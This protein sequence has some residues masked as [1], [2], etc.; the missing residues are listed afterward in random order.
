MDYDVIHRF[1]EAAVKKKLLTL[2]AV[3]LI[4]LAAYA[5]IRIPQLKTEDDIREAVL[6][7]EF[8]KTGAASKDARVYY[9]SV[10]SGWSKRSLSDG[11]PVLDTVLNAFGLAREETDRWDGPSASSGL[12]GRFS[13][14]KPPVRP[15]SECRIRGAMGVTDVRRANKGLVFVTGRINW[16]SPT[17]IEVEGG[18]YENGTSASGS[19]YTLVRRHGHWIVVRDKLIWIS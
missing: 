16:L 12:V 13:V 2:A 8:S 3:V 19:I 10:I 7:Y 15:A 6:R 5:A 14:H 11:A 17:K 9:L 1:G 4:T 18:Y